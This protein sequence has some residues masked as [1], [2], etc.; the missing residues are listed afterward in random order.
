MANQ[1]KHVCYGRPTFGNLE[2]KKRS[3]CYNWSRIFAI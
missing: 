1:P 3:K 2:I